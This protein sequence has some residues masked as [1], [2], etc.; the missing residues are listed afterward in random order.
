[1]NDMEDRKQELL[2][3]LCDEFCRYPFIWNEEKEGLTLYDAKCCSC[4]LMEFEN[5]ERR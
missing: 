3:M 2:N 1:M 4:P 5:Y